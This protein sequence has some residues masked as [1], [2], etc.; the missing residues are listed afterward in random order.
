M[1]AQKGEGHTGWT[2]QGVSREQNSGP[3]GQGQAA[4]GK[5]EIRHVNAND[6]YGLTIKAGNTGDMVILTVTPR[7]GLQAEPSSAR[8]HSLKIRLCISCWA[9]F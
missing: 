9:L 5:L 6:I 4:D 2:W 7:A 8:S 3:W 1:R